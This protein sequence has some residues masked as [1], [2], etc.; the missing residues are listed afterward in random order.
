MTEGKSPVRPRDAAS[1]VIF[2]R[3]RSESAGAVAEHVDVLVGRRSD[4]ARFK[5]GMYVF[6]G[7]GLERADHRV[8]PVTELDPGVVTR[9][10]VGGSA[11]RAHALALAAIR[12]TWEE[13]GLMFGAP[14]DVGDNPSPSWQAFRTQGIA[15]ALDRL[16][17]LGRAITPS[18]QPIRFHARFFAAE[19]SDV[20][21]EPRPSGELS[22]VQWVAL[23]D[24]ARLNLMPVTLLMLD[25]LKRR[26]EAQDTRAAFLSFQ[27][28]RRQ[29][30][31]V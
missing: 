7:G 24:T 26:L 15:P 16:A 6:P 14:G 30:L 20:H 29:I 11:A 3:R 28:G 18:P 21:G 5:P 1:L 22:D 4:R 25:A 12:E 10:A 27:H 17:Y 31:W 19:V 9:L 8:R 23:A 13:V 2:R